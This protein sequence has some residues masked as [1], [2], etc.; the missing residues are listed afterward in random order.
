MISCASR[1]TRGDGFGFLSIF[2]YCGCSASWRPMRFV[3]TP[4]VHQPGGRARRL[5]A[6]AHATGRS[7]TTFG[8]EQ[9]GDMRRP[10][11]HR[12]PALVLIIVHVVD[13]AHAA[14]ALARRG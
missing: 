5:R 6:T 4:P 11:F 14:E 12:L 10:G 1:S 13:A 9:S 2:L 7:G 3:L 8:G